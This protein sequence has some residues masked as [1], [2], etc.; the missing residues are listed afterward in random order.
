MSDPRNVYEVRW[1][2][3]DGHHFAVTVWAT[4]IGQARQIAR[5]LP[6]ARRA[7]LYVRTIEMRQKDEAA[8]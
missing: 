6:T 7:R 5:E 2:A 3:S 8:A 4:S 1:T